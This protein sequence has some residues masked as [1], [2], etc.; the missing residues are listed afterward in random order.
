VRGDRVARRVSPSEGG[1]ALKRNFMNDQ[2][3]LTYPWSVTG[4]HEFSS[5]GLSMWSR[6][7]SGA[8]LMLQEPHD[9][10]T[11]NVKCKISGPLDRVTTKICLLL[12]EAN[13]NWVRDHH[14]IDF[15]ESGVRTESHQTEHFG[16]SNSMI[17]TMY[18][19]DQTQMHVYGVHVTPDEI[20]YLLDG[21]DAAGPIPNESP[22]VLWQP[23]IRTEP[24]NAPE[25][26]TE[27]V[28]RY[29]EIV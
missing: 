9:Y 10:A 1:H 18:D 12:W 5:G 27:M 29:L 15:N 3:A 11:W 24:H 13:G 7:G 6:N 4:D 16:L 19:V 17:H 2:T 26:V 28:V 20:T 21:K 8:W 23:H 14:E 22:G 25:D